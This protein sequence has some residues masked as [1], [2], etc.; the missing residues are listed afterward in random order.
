MK[1]VVDTSPLIFLAKLNVL[2]LLPDPTATTPEVIAEVEAGGATAQAEI[3]SIRA[4][5]PAR[6]LIV[7]PRAKN[8][9]PPPTLLEQARLGAGET[10]AIQLALDAD[11]QEIIL[12]DRLAIRVAKAVGLQPISTAFLLLRTRRQGRMTPREYEGRLDRLVHHGYFLSAPL[13]RR[14]VDEGRRK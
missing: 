12:D 11:L 10:S 1:A 14:L 8:A 5:Q 6:R 13:Y 9:P 3:V 2:D 7:Q 4:L